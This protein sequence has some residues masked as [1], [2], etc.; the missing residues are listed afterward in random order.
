M[1]NLS[2]IYFILLSY[3]I[4]GPQAIANLIANFLVV[5]PFFSQVVEFRETT[6]QMTEP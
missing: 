5:L 2:F 1:F 4:P 3:A 6:Q